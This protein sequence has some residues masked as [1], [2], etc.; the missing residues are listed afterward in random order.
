MLLFELGWNKDVTENK[1]IALNIIATYG[2]SLFALVCG[3]FTSRWVLESLGQVDYGLFGVVGG[4]TMF[5][6]FFNNLLSAGVGR[7]FAVSIGECSV[8]PV[9]GMKKT[10][11]WFNTAFLIHLTVPAILMLIGYPLGEYAISN[12]WLNIPPDRLDACRWVFRFTCISCFVAMVNVPFMAMYTAKQYIA[13]LT[14]YS[15]VTTALNICFVYYMVS[16]PGDWLVRY[17]LWMCLVNAVPQVVICLR[18]M[19]IFPECKID[20]SYFWNSSRVKSLMGYS[21]WISFGTLGALL[22]SQGIAILINH[23]FGPKVN[24]AMAIGNQVSGQVST[25]SS[26]MQGAFSPAIMNAYGAGEMDKMRT[27]SYRACKLGTLLLL[28][29]LLP[30]ALELEY[31]LKLWLKNPPQYTAGLCWCVLAM[32]LIDKTAIGHM[33]AVNASGKIAAYHVSLGGAL[34]LTLPLAYLF[35]KLGWG[36]YSVGVAMVAT[37]AFCAWGRVW[38][39]RRLVGMSAWYWLKRVFLPLAVLILM[40]GGVGLAVQ[41]VMGVSFF[42]LLLSMLSVEIVLVVSSWAFVLDK[43]E[44]GFLVEKVRKLIEKSSRRRR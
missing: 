37:T 42:R 29:F 21:G 23:S 13:E 41:S 8:N 24:S 22:R 26:A 14:V 28:V 4:L 32:M 7:F 5:I 25:L 15:F 27:L 2:R 40:A 20:K 34:I 44:K 39:A 6:A 16:N 30:I 31:I 3:L 19:A 35:V 18:A 12:F 1:R 17:A 33:I 11:Q 9:D 36:V 10:Q 43:D 38:F